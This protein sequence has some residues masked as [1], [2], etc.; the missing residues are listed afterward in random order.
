MR[1]AVWVGRL[2]CAKVNL[3]QTILELVFMCGVG[4]L[5]GKRTLT[6]NPLHNPFSAWVL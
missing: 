3:K 4:F 5:G 1:V 6:S 2:F